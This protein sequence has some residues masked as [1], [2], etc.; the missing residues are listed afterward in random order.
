MSSRHRS[1]SR[2]PKFQFDSPPK[3]PIIQQQEQIQNE[4]TEEEALLLQQQQ[5][6]QQQLSA[7]SDPHEDPNKI[8]QKLNQ[9]KAQQEL[10]TSKADRKIYIGNI[11]Q[12][13]LIPELCQV[14]NT[15]LAKLEVNIDVTRFPRSALLFLLIHF[16]AGGPP[17]APAAS[18]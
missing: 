4:P 10:T 6:L 14:L 7:G 16:S 5:Q 18:I 1:R 2:S 3:D 12:N 17:R 9:I 11:P 8:I 15:A 13:I